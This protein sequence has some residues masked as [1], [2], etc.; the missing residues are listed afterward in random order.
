[1]NCRPG[2]HVAGRSQAKAA[3]PPQKAPTPSSLWRGG[4]CIHARVRHT[5]TAPQL[6][7]SF[8]PAVFRTAAAGHSQFPSSRTPRFNC[9]SHQRRYPPYQGSCVAYLVRALVFQG[10]VRTQFPVPEAHLASIQ[11]SRSKWR[12]IADR[13]TRRLIIRS[14]NALCYFGSAVRRRRC[15]ARSNLAVHSFHSFLLLLP[16][17]LKPFRRLYH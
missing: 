14:G 1:M 12:D 7:L 5:T 4:A 17:R 16:R 2:L 3:A 6:R 13:T 8:C 15:D 11:R 9:R 10:V